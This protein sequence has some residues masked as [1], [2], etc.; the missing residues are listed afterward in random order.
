MSEKPRPIGPEGEPGVDRRDGDQPE[1]SALVEGKAP[2][3]TNPPGVTSPTEARAKDPV[4][5]NLEVSNQQID[6]Q[7]QAPE[8]E[9]AMGE[10]FG[11]NAEEIINNE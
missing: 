10:I 2:V 9:L 11:E 7:A 6:L 8:L 3:E 1:P 5:P 4:V